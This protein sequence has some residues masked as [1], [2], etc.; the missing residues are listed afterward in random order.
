[1]Y[2]GKQQVHFVADEK[3]FK[4]YL[5]TP[6]VFIIRINVDGVEYDTVIQDVQYHP[7][8]D[9]ILHIDFLQVLADKPVTISVPIKPEG[10]PVGVLKGGKFITKMRKL[11]IRALAKDIPDII[12]LKTDHLDIGQSMKVS[13]VRLENV[14]FLDSPNNIIVGVRTARS[15][16]EEAPGAVAAGGDDKK[17]EAKK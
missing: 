13:D 8:T 15:V 1:M 3:S 10:T 5:F 16:V 4:K 12:T 6:E 7:V 9:N 11:K 14:S 17:D 2:G